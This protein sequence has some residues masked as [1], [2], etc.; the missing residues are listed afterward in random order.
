M[1]I[2]KSLQKLYSLHTFGI[3][4][5]LKNVKEFLNYIGNPQKELRAFHIAGSNGKGSTTA[6]ISS[7]LMEMNFK[8]GMYTSPHFVRFNERVKINN[9]E[10]SDYYI[11]NFVSDYE[12]Y[13]DDKQL[14]F[15]EVT[16]A[17]AFK[18][19][20]EQNVDYAVIETGLGG[21]LDATNVLEPLSAVITSISLEHTN[22]LGNTIKEVAG[23]KAGIIKPGCKV[24]I[25]KL[26]GDAEEIMEER[27]EKNKCK[28]FKL[29]DHI[30]EKKDSLELYDENIEFNDRTIP[31]KGN[32]QKFNAALAGL[33]VSKTFHKTDFVSIRNGVK[34][35][36]I[37]T[38][39]QGR[40]EFFK[41]NPDIVFDSAHNV[42]G[43]KN[44]ISEFKKDYEKYSRKV[45]LF[46]VMRDKAI[47]EMLLNIKDYFD[48]VYI[49]EI[50]NERSS[51]IDDLLKISSRI[52]LNVKIQKDPAQLLTEF[53][54]K[55]EN[56]C[57]V[58]LGSMYLIGEIKSKLINKLT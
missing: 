51:K 19:F 58:C 39:F 52:N 45:L 47:E 18:Y 24:F 7:I 2:E 41:K 55:P 40:Y 12:K 4:L 43:I 6:F 56:E 14:T 33:T 32:Y 5:G 23:E 28:L 27:S 31:L 36:L 9:I 50:D 48:E 42:E 20:A 54:T 26:P 13:I 8:A 34:N 11:A 44:F 35:I 49:T 29:K 1:N 21:R 25:G 38:G 46:G 10:I 3:K 37:N 57:L 16:T 53:E 15:F 30:I 17:M 22:V